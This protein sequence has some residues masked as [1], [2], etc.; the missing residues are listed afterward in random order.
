MR[1]VSRFILL[2]I[3]LT[4][5]SCDP[6]GNDDC[7]RSNY[8]GQF[9]IVSK[10]N[11]KDLLFGA[12]SVYDKT[13]LRFYALNGSD[14]TFFEYSPIK[15]SGNGYDSVVSVKFFPETSTPVY[16]KLSDTD[17]DTL[18]VFYKTFKS[19]C[20][21]MITEITKYRYNNLIDIAGGP[22]VQEIKKE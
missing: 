21:G 15:F 16:I 2:I 7:I 18:N 20:C 17:T 12:A 4:L 22:G 10:M 9:R 11:G 5:F 13:N 19:K 8:S 14:T 1:Q 6:C 3:T